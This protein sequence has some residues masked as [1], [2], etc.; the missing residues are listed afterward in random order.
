MPSKDWTKLAETLDVAFERDWEI[1][2]ASGSRSTIRR[3][4]S[5]SSNYHLIWTLYRWIKKQIKND[6][7][8][9]EPPIEGDGMPSIHGSPRRWR[10]VGGQL[11]IRK[12]DLKQ[13][14]GGPLFDENDELLIGPETAV[15]Q[16]DS[17]PSTIEQEVEVCKVEW[18]FIGVP[19]SNEQ[20]IR[21]RAGVK[22]TK[23]RVEALYYASL[24]HASS[25][26][27]IVD[28][29]PMI[30]DH[31]PLL[32]PPRRYM[33]NKGWR[34]DSKSAHLL[35]EGPLFSTDG[36]ILVEASTGMATRVNLEEIDSF[37][38]SLAAPAHAVAAIL[39]KGFLPNYSE[40]Q[41]KNAIHLIIGDDSVSK[42]WGGKLPMSF[43]SRFYWAAAV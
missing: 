27:G 14:R 1:A 8:L 25:A 26:T 12:S 23:C 19:D 15:G 39:D 24:L 16:G 30:R 32:I 7:T 37:S 18:E 40:D 5:A 41:V 43:R 6:P 36:E 22:V 42:D 9:G 21:P 35:E 20:Q 34:L 3:K 33:L 28:P 4:S 38:F 31:P 11:Q 10:W 2:R 17:P 29:E 13:L